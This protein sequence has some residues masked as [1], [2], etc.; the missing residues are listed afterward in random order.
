MTFAIQE[1]KAGSDLGGRYDRT[2]WHTNGVFPAEQFEHDKD[3]VVVVVG[4]EKAFHIDEG[5]VDHANPFSALKHLAATQHDVAFGILAGANLVDYIARHGKGPSAAADQFPDPNRGVHG[6]PGIGIEIETHK[7]VSGKERLPDQLAPPGVTPKLL[8]T[9]QVGAKALVLE[10]DSSTFFASLPGLR[11]E[12]T[13][14]KPNFHTAPTPSYRP[15]TE[16][17]RSP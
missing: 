7:D 17:R 6:A 11:G 9:R 13:L 4:H 8:K 3:A 14:A 12:P 1:Q 10:I 2:A 16:P 15:E 5:P